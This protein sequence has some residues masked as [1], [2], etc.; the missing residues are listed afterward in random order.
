[1]ALKRNSI[2]LTKIE[3]GDIQLLEKEAAKR[4]SVLPIII[5]ILEQATVNTH[6]SL[7]EPNWTIKRARKDGQ[8]ALVN[9]LKRCFGED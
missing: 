5:K 4:K 6:V 8:E 3:D 9:D 2:L 7:E 1:M